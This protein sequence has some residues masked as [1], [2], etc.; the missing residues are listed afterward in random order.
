[1]DIR[2]V[3]ASVALIALVF[4]PVPVR[5]QRDPF[6][7]NERL[8]IGAMGANDVGKASVLIR[9]PYHLPNRA[10]QF[11]SA[12]AN[13]HSFI[14]LAS[15]NNCQTEI[16]KELLAHGEQPGAVPEKAQGMTTLFWAID[17]GQTCPVFLEK[18]L[19][20]GGDPNETM[21]MYTGDRL[22]YKT[23]SI[24]W[25][26]GNEDCH[27]NRI[28]RLKTLRN[29]G[30][31]VN[32]RD[33]WG[34]TPLMF[35]S[36]SDRCL[37]YAQLVLASGYPGGKADINATTPEGARAIDLATYCSIESGAKTVVAF[38]LQNGSLPARPT[39]PQ[40]CDNY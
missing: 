10:I 2:Q 8:L 5:A 26:A 9:S 17:L 14:W 15:W 24:F 33:R 3:L 4:S 20:A 18:Y 30:V 23:P 1:M 40:R 6:A 16:L 12:D 31:D 28:D 34:F 19:S 22:W 36:H 27:E 7:D 11:G 25:T 32:A 37:A 38:L 35:F 29:H 13:G 39:R 21:D